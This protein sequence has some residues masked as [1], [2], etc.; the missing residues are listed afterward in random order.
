MNAHQ[1][2]VSIHFNLVQVICRGFFISFGQ[3]NTVFFSKT[4]RLAQS[5]F[6]SFRHFITDIACHLNNYIIYLS[7]RDW[8]LVDSNV[9]HNTQMFTITL[10]KF[11]M[12]LADHSFLSLE[13]LHDQVTAVMLKSRILWILCNLCIYSY[14][15]KCY[16]SCFSTWP[17]SRGHAKPFCIYSRRWLCFPCFLSA[18]FAVLFR[19]LLREFFSRKHTADIFIATAGAH[20]GPLYQRT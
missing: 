3:S 8:T 15:T 17:S 4:Y 16:C 20:D 7:V 2:S 18:D 6:R 9:H 10:W 13:T 19:R 14:V 5:S 11:D 12:F 1:V